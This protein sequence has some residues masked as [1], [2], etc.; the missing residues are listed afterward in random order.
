MSEIKPTTTPR[1]QAEVDAAIAAYAN[2]ATQIDLTN[3]EVGAAAYCRET[4]APW[5]RAYDSSQP[6]VEAYGSSQPRVEASKFTQVSVRGQVQVTAHADTPVL[7]EG[8][9][10]KI[11]GGRQTVI[12]RKTPDEWCAYYGVEVK[13]GVA[14]LFKGV[15]DRFKSGHGFAYVPGT[16]PEAPD[17]DGSKAECGGGLHFSP[18]PKMTLEFYR[19]ATKFVACPVALDDI[20]VHPDG[21]Y[22]QKI[23]ARRICAPCWEVNEDGER[24]AA[25]E[26]S[27]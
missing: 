12:A 11:D 13:D 26:V 17:W 6:R 10:A 9:G 15:D 24:V 3:L 16:A 1:T 7:V 21:A 27:L 20:V 18:R 4:Q 5:L 23:K 25:K 14:I 19:E 8:A 22:P 2:G